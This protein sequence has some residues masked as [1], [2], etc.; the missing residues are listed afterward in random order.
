MFLQGLDH[1][2]IESQLDAIIDEIGSGPQLL[3]INSILSFIFVNTFSRGIPL[4]P[5]FISQP[6]DY[7]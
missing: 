5:K 4:R 6:T 1:G 3:Q 2:G 7:N